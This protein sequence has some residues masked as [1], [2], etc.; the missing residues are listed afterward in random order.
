MTASLSPVLQAFRCIDEDGT[1]LIPQATLKAV[2]VRL[3]PKLDDATFQ[4]MV[5]AACETTAS[6]P[7]SYERFVL[8]LCHD[9]IPTSSSNA[10]K[11]AKG[12]PLT[13]PPHRSDDGPPVQ[14][15]SAAEAATTKADVQP[16]KATAAA[17]V[18]ASPQLPEESFVFGLVSRMAADHAG[19]VAMEMKLDQALETLRSLQQRV[20]KASGIPVE[21][22]LQMFRRPTDGSSL[23]LDLSG[24]AGARLCSSVGLA[25]SLQLVLAP[26][27]GLAQSLLSGAGVRHS[28]MKG[29]GRAD[30][31][32]MDAAGRKVYYVHSGNHKVYCFDMQSSRSAE[33][34]T[35]EQSPTGICFVDGQL[36]LTTSGT[37]AR[38]FKDGRLLGVSP[39]SG[40]VMTLLSGLQFPRALAAVPGG[41]PG[42]APL[43]VFFT[44]ALLSHSALCEFSNGAR[45]CVKNLP[46]SP[47]G[48][49]AILDGV[50]DLVAIGCHGRS[51]P[52]TGGGIYVVSTADAA[53]EPFLAIGDELAANEALAVD[54]S[55]CLYCAG[56]AGG[57][58]EGL[59]VFPGF[60]AAAAR[61]LP[62]ICR[63][64]CDEQVQVTKHRKTQSVYQSIKGLAVSSDGDVVFYSTVREALRFCS[65]TAAA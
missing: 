52:G 1:G 35:L 24:E 9:E 16:V 3:N 18:P 29:A 53:E 55:G 44:E 12:R 30:S 46:F 19:A 60:A 31:I 20:A 34:A 2:L 36:L 48:G 62:Y 25:G 54:S 38:Q 15:P 50:G 13:A 61:R 27:L 63:S 64:N 33:L 32:C 58:R 57:A 10:A 41:S 42:A 11:V 40:A 59:E 23:A 49:L 5:W 56:S 4:H 22:L 45:R 47:L 26:C 8:W 14:P 37:E 28:A 21:D 7:V 6:S 65:V 17:H 51:C 39:S 43:R